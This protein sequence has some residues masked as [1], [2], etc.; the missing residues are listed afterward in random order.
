[1]VV[2]VIINFFHASRNNWTPDVACRLQTYHTT[3]TFVKS[4]KCLNG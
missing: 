3:M 4:F 1:M 2:Y